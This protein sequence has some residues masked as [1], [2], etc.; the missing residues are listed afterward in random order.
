MVVV[1]A[2]RMHITKTTKKF[3]EG[4]K[5]RIKIYIGS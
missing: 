3:T 1:E 2:S 5:I 4:K